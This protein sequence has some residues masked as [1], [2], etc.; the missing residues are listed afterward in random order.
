[1]TKNFVPVLPRGQSVMDPKNV[2]EL[3]VKPRSTL[4]RLGGEIDYFLVWVLIQMCSEIPRC[5]GNGN[6]KQKYG[7]GVYGN[8]K[9][10]L[11][12]GV[13]RKKSF[14]MT[15]TST[16][17]VD[18]LKLDT[19]LIDN[20]STNMYLKE[21]CFHTSVRNHLC[22][23]VHRAIHFYLDWYPNSTQKTDFQW[24]FLV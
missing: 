3:S 21:I 10:Q 4:A 5:G 7:G 8:K 23:L 11:C 17:T 6:E 1:M 19:Y 14:G 13:P 18:L 24:E 15:L 22:D 16:V 2:L 9:M 12:M 20:Y